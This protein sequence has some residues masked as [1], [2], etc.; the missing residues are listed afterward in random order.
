MVWMFEFLSEV[1]QVMAYCMEGWLLEYFKDR[2]PGGARAGV[3][4][5]AILQPQ[6]G[7]QKE[8]QRFTPLSNKSKEVHKYWNLS[9]PTSGKTRM[10]I[11]SGIS[12]N[13]D[14]SHSK[15]NVQC[16]NTM[17]YCVNRHA[18]PSLFRRRQRCQYFL[19]TLL[20]VEGLLS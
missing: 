14:G 10:L 3:S 16:E 1:L 18:I 4:W 11:C 8:F 19:D 6:V 2:F 9:G 17:E 15:G 7:I 5:P 12:Q 13:I 20:A